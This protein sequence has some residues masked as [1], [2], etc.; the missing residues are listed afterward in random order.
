MSKALGGTE[1]K[2][3]VGFSTKRW[4]LV[5][6]SA[7]V[8]ALGGAIAPL[9][10]ASA[11]MN[12]V[13]QLG[14]FQ[15]HIVA[16]SN[17]P[18]N[19]DTNPYGM[20]IVPLTMGNLVKGD[21]LVAEFNNSANT[22]GAGTSIVQVNPMT[23]AVTQF[24]S[25]ATL[26]NGALTGPV[27][28]AINPKN[29]F[30]WV[31]AFGGAANGSQ[32]GYVV[33]NSMGSLVVD[34]NNQTVSSN[35]T[36]MGNMNPFAGVWGAAVGIDYHTKTTS[37]YWSNIAGTS[38]MA[39]PG[40]I[41]RTNPSGP[42]L[43]Q[44]STFTPIVVGLPA[45][46]QALTGPKGMVFDEKNG[47]LFFTDSQN[48]AVY[49]VKDAATAMGPVAPKLIYQGGPLSTPQDIALDPRTGHLYVVNG[50][51]GPGTANALI[52]L[53][54]SGQILG[55][56]DLAPSEAPGGLFGIAIPSK[57][58]GGLP[59]IYYDNANDSNIHVLMK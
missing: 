30:V 18:I 52:E 25:A 37:F 55:I 43:Y 26:N 39:G 15:D 53:T 3:R 16:P 31:A 13:G 58:F 17:N 19:G 34:E 8:L 20:A 10:S 11:Q 57:T 23:G 24:A 51:S 47:T 40:E 5:S 36:L 27:D 35:P 12:P 48:N 49:A 9:S 33:I 38:S 59:V 44:N 54:Q 50:A 56:R 32:S 29:D 41:W 2:K 4:M 45:S 1:S 28:I 6:G 21:L 22:S 7:S 46:A 42:N 14:K